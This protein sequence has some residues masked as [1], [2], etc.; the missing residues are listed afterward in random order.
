MGRNEEER[1]GVA[2]TD[3]FSVTN[4]PEP[5]IHTASAIPNDVFL[6]GEHAVTAVPDLGYQ[7]LTPLSV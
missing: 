2:R 3:V 4:D 7:R 1:G 5:I 6:W